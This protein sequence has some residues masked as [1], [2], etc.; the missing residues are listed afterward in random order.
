MQIWARDSLPSFEELQPEPALLASSE[1]I[2]TRAQMRMQRWPGKRSYCHTIGSPRR[3]E[4]PL[5]SARR[6]LLRS[7]LLGL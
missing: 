3:R 2:P 5:H 7:E 6:A 1:T 4:R